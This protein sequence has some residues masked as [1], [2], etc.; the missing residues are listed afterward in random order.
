VCANIS[1]T[2]KLDERR[3]MLEVKKHCM[4]KMER[5]KVPVKIH[6]SKEM[7]HTGRF[8]KKRMGAPRGQAGDCMEQRSSEEV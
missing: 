5:Y 4:Q 2:G 6:L 8:K 7:Q 3:L 1:I